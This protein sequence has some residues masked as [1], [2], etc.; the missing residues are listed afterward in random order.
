MCCMC[1]LY[2]R[3]DEEEKSNSMTLPIVNK[4]FGKRFASLLLAHCGSMGL[5]QIQRLWCG[6]STF[7]WN[8]HASPSVSWPKQGAIPSFFGFAKL[9]VY[10]CPLDGNHFLVSSLLLW[11]LARRPNC[12]CICPLDGNHF[13]Y[14]CRSLAKFC[15]EFGILNLEYQQIHST[16]TL[17]TKKVGK[18]KKTFWDCWKNHS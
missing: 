12:R 7:W 4:R 15:G 18:Q 1:F 9:Q 8:G 6:F 3:K 5:W 17:S 11:S 16:V 2:Q 13:L 10:M 14:N